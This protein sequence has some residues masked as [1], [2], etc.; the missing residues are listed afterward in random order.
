MRVVGSAVTSV[1]VTVS[2]ATAPSAAAPAASAAQPVVAPRTQAIGADAANAV[3]LAG[4]GGSVAAAATSRAAVSASA[5]A[6]T[7]MARAQQARVAAGLAGTPRQIAKVLLA[8]RGWG[9]RQFSC[10]DHLWTKESDWTATADNPTSDAYGIPQSLPGEKMAAAGKDW[11]TNPAT[12]IRW[13][14]TYIADV[15]GTPC[16]AWAHSRATDWY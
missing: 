1:T 15:Y 5:A 9:A 11:R 7:A 13:G 2:P 16:E 4:G 8:K 12:Q 14:L 10:L 6:H 3:L